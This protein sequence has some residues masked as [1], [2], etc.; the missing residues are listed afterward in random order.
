MFSRNTGKAINPATE[1][2]MKKYCYFSS[3]T[4]STDQL[5]SVF[6]RVP[7]PWL[8]KTDCWPRQDIVQHGRTP[9]FCP[10]KQ[11]AAGRLQ[12]TVTAKI[13]GRYRMKSCRQHGHSGIFSKLHMHLR[14]LNMQ[15]RGRRNRSTG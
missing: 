12:P 8:G 7:S 6:E 3:R 15:P 2:R 9:H 11:M 10:P 14:I 5:K 1:V 13:Y 4:L